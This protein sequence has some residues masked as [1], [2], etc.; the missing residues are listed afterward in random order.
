MGSFLYLVTGQCLLYFV[1][2]FDLQGPDSGLQCLVSLFCFAQIGIIFCKEIAVFY[3]R[4]V[5]KTRFAALV[6]KAAKAGI[7]VRVETFF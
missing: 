3:F 2:G 4:P 5:C 1:N 7:K 6:L